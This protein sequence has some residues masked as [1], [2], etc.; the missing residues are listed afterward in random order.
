[1]QISAILTPE[2]VACD[3]AVASKKGVLE[4]LSELLVVG[5]VHL[6]HSEIFSSL[7]TRERLG[8]TGLGLGVAI[9]HGRIKHLEGT[10][11]AFIKV[12]RGIDFDAVD[13]LPVDVFFALLVPDHFTDE[14]LAVLSRLAEMFS[15]EPFLKMLRVGSSAQEIYDLLTRW[16]DYS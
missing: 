13:N 9:P 12:R 4:A 5:S 16:P 6:S 8:S 2:R 15:E 14:H 10:V 1:M 3:H 11:G 7:V